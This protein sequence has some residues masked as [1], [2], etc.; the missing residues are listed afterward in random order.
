MNLALSLIDKFQIQKPF[1]SAQQVWRFVQY[2]Q[3]YHTSS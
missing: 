2:G 3:K 1:E